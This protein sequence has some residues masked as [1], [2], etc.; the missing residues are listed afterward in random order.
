MNNNSS[1][2]RNVLLVALL[3][4]VLTTCF[5]WAWNASLPAIFGVSELQ[6]KQATGLIVL[7]SIASAFLGG[8]RWHRQGI[9]CLSPRYSDP[10]ADLS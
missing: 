6:F 8:P 7:L 4:L 3:F 2:I 5:Y 10:E 1:N 9:A